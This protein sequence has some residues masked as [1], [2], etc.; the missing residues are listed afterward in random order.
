MTLCI[1]TVVNNSYQRYLSL[2]IYFCLISY[3]YYGIRIFLTG[4]LSDSHREHIDELKKRGDVEIFEHVFKDFPKGNQ[5]LKTLRWIIGPEH[6]EDYENIYIGDIDMLICR[7]DVDLMSQHLEH[8]RKNDLP[9]SNAIRSGTSRLSGLHF[10]KKDEYYNTMMATIEEYKDLLRRGKLKGIKNEEILYKM[11]K[12]AGLGLPKGWFRPHHGIH[13]GLWRKGERKVS[14]PAWKV[15]NRDMYRE[16]YKF[17][18]LVAS[19]GDPL[20]DK[21]ASIKELKFMERSLNKEFME[22]K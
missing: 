10:V 15:I 19:L 11:V 12:K 2:F 6:F 22:V 1:S 8:C 18:R 21:I 16:H 3:P 20:F 7:E 14:K 5:E 13:L 9:Y 17:Y 4:A